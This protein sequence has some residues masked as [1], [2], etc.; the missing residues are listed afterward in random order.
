MS[1][2][3]M[4]QKY[5]LARH[6]H[7]IEAFTLIEVPIYH[8]SGGNDRL[9]FV[10]D[11]D[12]LALRPNRSFGWD[13]I[14]GDC[15]T[16]DRVSPVNRS[17]WLRGLMHSVDAS[18]GIVLLGNQHRVEQ[19]HK[20]YASE[21]SVHIYTESEFGEYDK[22]IVFPYGSNR[23]TYIPST[24]LSLRQLPRRFDALG[25]F[26]NYVFH[27]S[28]ME[29]NHFTTLRKVLGA[30]MG[31]SGEID[32][33]K[34]DHVALVVLATSVFAVHLAA[35][36]GSIFS[37]F[38]PSAEKISIE[39][40]LKNLVWGGRDNYEM[41]LSLRSQLLEAKGK[42]SDEPVELVFPYWENFVDLITVLLENPAAA[43]RLPA[44]FQSFSSDL[45]GG[46]DN[47]ER[48]SKSDLTMLK[49]AFLTLSYFIKASRWPIQLRQELEKRLLDIQ[50][51]AADRDSS[52]DPLIPK[53]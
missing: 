23:S 11:I 28:W 20:L 51:Q 52:I 46:T 13:V 34:T 14:L 5:T 50:T 4:Q 8:R 40:T 41:A 6:F 36:V 47:S 53:S 49:F 42:T 24:Q 2:K 7:E 25:N 39:M 33:R 27:S 48:Y 19:D 44:Y 1:T 16:G 45:A 3:D 26:V 10:T 17:L 18:E 21:F 22:A 30:S 32:P 15:K 12:V 29:V 43:F 31:I 35:C 37:S 9:A 38:L